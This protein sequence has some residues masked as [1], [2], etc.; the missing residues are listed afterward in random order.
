[1]ENEDDDN[2]ASFTKGG[3]SSLLSRSFEKGGRF[4]KGE[5]DE[6]WDVVSP[7]TQHIIRD[8]TSPPRT[9]RRRRSR[10]FNDHIDTVADEYTFLLI[11]PIDNPVHE[12]FPRPKSPSSLA[13]PAE[14]TG[15]NKGNPAWICVLYGLIN[16]TIVIPV[17]MSFGNIIYQ[18]EAFVP[19]MPV[20][21]R[22]TLISGVVHQICFSSLSSLKFV[23]GS[24]QDAGLI[25]LSAM[26]TDMV[27]FC[28]SRGL[29]DEAMLATVTICLGIAAAT[30]GFGLI[31]IG[32]L[33]LAGY[34]Q[35]LPTCI[36]AGYLAYIG[37]FCGK[38]GVAL[39]A[40]TQLTLPVIIDKFMFIVPG[41]AG[42][43][44]IYFSV[45]TFRHVVVLPMTI[46]I[47]LLLFYGSLVVSGSSIAQATRDGWIREAEPAPVWYRSWDYLQFDKVAWSVLPRLLV[48]EISMILVVA[49]SSSLDVAA[50][51]LEMEGPLNYNHE[52]TMVGISNVISGLTGGYT[53]SYIFSQTIFTLRA[54]IR[55]RLAGFV[56][57]FCMISVIVTPFPILSY[58]PNFFYGSL[59]SMIC[60]DLMYEWLWDFRDKVTPAEYIIALATFCLIQVLQVEYGIL[61]GVFLY[62]LCR[63]FGVD[64]G[65]LNMATTETEDTAPSSEQDTSIGLTT[66]M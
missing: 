14:T 6:K 44:F 65:E 3:S 60:I 20:L 10:S 34:V 5:Y 49:L 9:L 21:I 32:R 53:G 18:N 40:G 64:V 62:V 33:R 13:T 4:L 59:L 50:I 48:R 55:E 23:V 8:R 42:G 43:L 19:Y 58:V 45:K 22:L 26:A 7:M 52:L 1:M 51:E 16:A 39:M 27:D 11:P 36:I 35:L 47:L 17:V 66:S 30:L 46:I 56:L 2:N 37:W 31:I 29:D 41:I 25:F 61:A 38:S 24:V 12:S 57:A 15:E 54:G 28:R 63:Q